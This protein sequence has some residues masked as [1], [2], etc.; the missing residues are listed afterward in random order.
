LF[1][2]GDKA[3]KKKRSRLLEDKA[4]VLRSVRAELQGNVDDSV[5]R[6]LDELI[7]SIEAAGKHKNPKLSAEHLLL[8]GKILAMLPEIIDAIN[9]LKRQ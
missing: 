6:Q 4:V 8:L 3:V 1:N 5:I 7:D 9:R 2:T